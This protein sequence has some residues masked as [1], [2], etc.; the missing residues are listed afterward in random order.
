[1]NPSS[2]PLPPPPKLAIAFI[3]WWLPLA[4]DA[5]APLEPV[6]PLVP[7]P[8]LATL[9]PLVPDGFQPST[10]RTSMSVCERPMVSPGLPVPNTSCWAKS[11]VSP[12]LTRVEPLYWLLNDRGDRVVPPLYEK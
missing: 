3:N 5:E 7:D 11:A 8:L 1:M 12:P 6:D 9:A 4:S 2:V 10:S